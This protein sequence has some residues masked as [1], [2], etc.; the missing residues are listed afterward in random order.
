MRAAADA[1]DSHPPFSSKEVRIYSSLD[2]LTP[3]TRACIGTTLGGAP[4]RV[5]APTDRARANKWCPLQ[6]C[7]THCKRLSGEACSA[8][9][10][11]KA[12]GDGSDP[13]E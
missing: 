13:V 9:T 5:G 3:A 12:G 7:K 8:H 6:C 2:A 1:L 4:C 10:A 11:P